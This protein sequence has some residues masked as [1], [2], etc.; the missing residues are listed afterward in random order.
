M[1]FEGV[2]ALDV[3]NLNPFSQRFSGKAGDAQ[4]HNARH[5]CARLIGN[6]EPDFER[7]LGG[8]VVETQ[9]RKQADYPAGNA[10]RRLRQTVVGS[11]RLAGQPVKAAPN[12]LQ[13]PG[14]VE[15]REII[16]RDAIPIKITWPQY[17][18]SF[19][20]IKNRGGF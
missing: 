8:K 3:V 15:Q 10:L 7:S 16:A 1:R 14:A 9:R 18:D 2:A 5:R 17:A 4:R 6:G 19:G 13:P 11:H 12:T 20:E